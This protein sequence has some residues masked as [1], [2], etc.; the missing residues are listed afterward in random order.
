[1]TVTIDVAPEM[2]KLLKGQA[3]KA[4]LT[5]E[6]Y[7]AVVLCEKAEDEEAA[8]SAASVGE[9]SDDEWIALL[10][11]MVVQVPAIPLEATR[12]ENLYDD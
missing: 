4:G 12:R 5:F 6:S 3:Q 10:Q 7:L 9:M 2:E 1:M 8:A 11:S